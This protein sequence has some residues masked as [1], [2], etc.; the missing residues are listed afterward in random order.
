MM[1]DI[2]IECKLGNIGR[3]SNGANFTP[4]QLGKGTKFVNLDDIYREKDLKS[5]DSFEYVT[6]KNEKNYLLEDGDILFVRSSVKPSGV[7]FPCLFRVDSEDKVVFCGFIIRFRYN[8]KLLNPKYL[9]YQL[10]LQGNRNKVIA[11]GQVVANTNINQKGLGSLTIYIHKS[12]N[13]QTTIATILSKVD[14][15]IEATQNSIKAAEKLK[16]ALMQNLLTGKLKPDGTWRTEDEFYLDEK[17]G[18]V[19]KG[20]KVFPVGAKSLCD[21]NPNYR[22]I[23]GK[24]YDFIPMDAIKDGFRGVDYLESNVIDG[25]GFTRFKKGDI[26]FAKITPCTENGKVALIEEMRS[27]IG[28]A[29][30]EFIVFHPKGTVDGLFFYYLL[31]SGRV[32]RLAVSL[33]E[34]TTGRQRVPWKIFK[35]RI[36]APIP[37]NLDEQKEIANKIKTVEFSNSDKQTKIQNLQRLKKAL[38]Q[39]LLTGKVRL[40][41]K[42]IKKLT[43]S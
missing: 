10:L 4:D 20:W 26:L 9:L 36:V 3:F 16:K 38:M 33:M 17:Y 37:L 11:R 27:E 2:M 29:S 41:E 5:S 35:N 28:F 30:T 25:G 18:K 32:H 39:N 34:G 42:L 22:Y 31:S 19:P 21:I 24:V 7:G 15:A 14:E 8:K 13:E 23:K 43:N 6:L 1:K 40:S 12:I